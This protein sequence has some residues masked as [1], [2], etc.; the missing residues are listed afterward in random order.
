MAKPRKVWRID[1]A[2]VMKE[3]L[4]MYLTLQKVENAEEVYTKLVI[5]HKAKLLELYGLYKQS[6]S[7]DTAWG[8]ALMDLVQANANKPKRLNQKTPASRVAWADATDTDDDTA[9]KPT[10]DAPFTEV[11]RRRRRQPQTPTPTTEPT[12]QPKATLKATDWE[13]NLPILTGLPDANS[14]G[15]GLFTS[16][17]IQHLIETNALRG[18]NKALHLILLGRPTDSLR[19]LAKQRGINPRLIPVTH[20]TSLGLRT[21]SQGYVWDVTPHHQLRPKAPADITTIDL[22]TTNPDGVMAMVI[23]KKY[24]P[25]QLW[26]KFYDAYADA[27]KQIT[28]AKSAPNIKREGNPWMPLHRLADDT[29]TLQLH[30]ALQTSPPT[31]DSAPAPTTGRVYSTR[32]HDTDKD[33][34]TISAIFEATATA[35]HALRRVSGTSG[36]FYRR[37]PMGDKTEFLAEYTTETYLHLPDD[38]TLDQALAKL[39]STADHRGL[40]LGFNGKTLT[41]RLSKQAAANSPLWKDTG[42]GDA[43][44]APKFEIRN[45]PARVSDTNLLRALESH[46][47]WK[48]TILRANR[49]GLHLK[50]V[51]VEAAHPPKTDRFQTQQGDLIYINALPTP[52]ERVVRKLEDEERKATPAP[53]KPTWD[54]FPPLPTKLATKPQAHTSLTLKEILGAAPLPPDTPTATDTPASTMTAPPPLVI[55]QALPPTDIDARIDAA[56]KQSELRI[57]AM[58]QRLL[59]PLLQPQALAP[60][61]L[62]LSTHDSLAAS[63]ADEEL[64]KTKRPRDDKDMLLDTI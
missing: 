51:L 32:L 25:P 63:A 57:E 59:A 7:G 20:Y 28:T 26:Q 3:A 11:R 34:P 2:Q 42:S 16:Q 36:V 21:S 31:G 13:G 39:A 14:T 9:A 18:A 10:D 49:L 4:V 41:L 50:R 48:P 52:A 40:G 53:W 38:T 37:T 30:A 8:K 24:A 54:D 1:K 19:A 27:A 17:G 46:L 22:P 6:G 12:Y 58:I 15:I 44:P 55:P 35:Q 33:A 23:S 56:V 47:D 60:Q 43:P 64:P 5:N 29:K 62:T 45:V 61:T